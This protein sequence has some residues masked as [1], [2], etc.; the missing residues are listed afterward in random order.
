MRCLKPCCR[1]VF[2]SARLQVAWPEWPIAWV[3]NAG[4]S[5]LEDPSPS[6]ASPTHSP[7]SL[8]QAHHATCPFSRAGG[9]TITFDAA[10]A[11]PAA[12][13]ARSSTDSSVTGSRR[14]LL[15]A[16]S[17]WRL[18]TILRSCRGFR[19]NVSA[20]QG[21]AGPRVGCGGAW[22]VAAAVPLAGGLFDLSGW[23]SVPCAEPWM[24]RHHTLALNLLSTALACLPRA[25]RK[26]LP[27]A[28]Q[29]LV[30]PRRILQHQ[31]DLQGRE[32]RQR[33]DGSGAAGQ[34]PA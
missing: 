10:S 13:D 18:S 16:S 25:S 21:H 2:F 9:A 32:G 34:E 23:H 33:K 6:I 1:A 12:G 5:C 17:I 28:C 15:V 7:L 31:R 30:L 29:P 20:R 26:C 14:Q 8:K 24:H 19:R 3:I 27:T 11:G 4:V 22:Q